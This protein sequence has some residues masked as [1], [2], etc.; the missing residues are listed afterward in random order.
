MKK[1]IGIL[2][3]CLMALFYVVP[4][5]SADYGYGVTL[6]LG[7]Y[8]TDGSETEKTVSGVTS[9]KTTKSIEESFYGASLYVERKFDNGFVLGLDYVPMDFELGSGKRTDV[10]G[11]GGTTGSQAADTD[12]GD[13]SAQADISNLITI[14]AHVP[15]GPAYVLLGYH[16]ADITTTETLPTSTYGDASVNGYQVGLGIKND[17]VKFEVAYSD[18]DDISLTSSANTNKIEASAD[19]LSARFSF[20]F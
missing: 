6:H 5:N 19:A 15:V 1:I 2:S 20:G 14:Y 9:E 11:D 7:T 8:E 13:R 17:N 12:D 10:D 3:F 4:A 16:D 18:F